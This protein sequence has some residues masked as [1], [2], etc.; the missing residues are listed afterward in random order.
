MS[1]AQRHEYKNI[2][3]ASPTTWDSDVSASSGVSLFSPGAG[4]F[5]EVWQIDVEGRA[6]NAAGVGVEIRDGASGDVIKFTEV[7]ARDVRIITFGG[8][9]KQFAT[10]FWVQTISESEAARMTVHYVPRKARS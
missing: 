6:S 8:L 5:L 2:F 3:L 7:A 10:T 9:P 1:R 4:E